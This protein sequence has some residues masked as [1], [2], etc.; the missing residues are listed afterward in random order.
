METKYITFRNLAELVFFQIT[1]IPDL[2]KI[3]SDL[4]KIA[5]IQVDYTFSLEKHFRVVILVDDETIKP[6]M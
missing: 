2:Y 3:K 6:T 1:K 4:Y 5:Q